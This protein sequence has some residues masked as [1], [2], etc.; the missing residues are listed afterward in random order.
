MRKPILSPPSA[1]N[2][3]AD[4]F[5]RYLPGASINKATRIDS[6]LGTDAPS[7]GGAV[8]A[9]MEIAIAAD[10]TAATAPFFIFARLVATF[11][12]HPPLFRYLLLITIVCYESPGIGMPRWRY[13]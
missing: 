11:E 10:N 12:V 9:D 13:A 8:H 3:A 6:S 7:D 1:E 4:V 5:N 2:V